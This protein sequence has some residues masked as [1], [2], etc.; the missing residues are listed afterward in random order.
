M[1][2]DFLYEQYQHQIQLKNFGIEAQVKLRHANILVIGLG[3]LGCPA[4]QYLSA[5]GIGRIGIM[6]GDTVSLSNLHRQILYTYQDIGQLKT[7]VVEKKI[8]GLNP[9]TKITLYTDFITQHN[10][11]D[12]ISN[13][14]IV[15][16][17]TDNFKA[18]YIINDACYLLNKPLVFGAV[19]QYEGQV[20]IFNH[21]KD[22]VNYRD[23]FP[24]SPK[25]NESPN[26]MQT[27]VYNIATAIIGTLQASEAIKLITGIGE[28]L[29]NKL[30]T[31]H[32]LKISSYTI[33]LTKNKLSLKERPS[34]RSEFE[35]YNYDQFCGI[36]SSLSDDISA[37]E[38]DQLIQSD[39]VQIIDIRNENELPK[40]N[41][42]QSIQIPLA[43]LHENIHLLDKQKK[44]ILFC[45]SGIR[46]QTAIELL[47]DDY[48]MSNV[49]HL[50]G[51]IIKWLD[52]K[53]KKND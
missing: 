8:L 18:R 42:F 35:S 43:S 10:A 24:Y 40:I 39:D 53:S 48:Q 37:E 30:L 47:H 20:S 7:S 50:K 21:G 25:E 1:E 15:L 3:G 19:F 13:Y 44:I 26:C 17:C 22:A 11:F 51:G 32:S 31:F 5:I 52:F 4:I 29:T 12:I 16:D 45:H 27:G 38:F 9:S 23:L 41:N 2:N 49:S 6:D 28:T 36:N 46:T 14:E 33:D 34:S